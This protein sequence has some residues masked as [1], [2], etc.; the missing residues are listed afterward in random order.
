[1]DTK[2]M[3]L[4]E[5]LKNTEKATR[6]FFSDYY[7]A[8]ILAVILFL[9]LFVIV[10]SFLSLPKSTACPIVAKDLDTGT[11]VI[12]AKEI[13]ADASFQLELQDK[14]DLND[15]LLKEIGSAFVKRNKVEKWRVDASQAKQINERQWEIRYQVPPEPYVILR[16][17]YYEPHV[18]TFRALFQ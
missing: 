11:V 12:T 7:V 4:S 1:M 9:A 3:L 5:K 17:F 16:A 15:N 6:N 2:E 10:D 13:P 14:R 8:I 18:S